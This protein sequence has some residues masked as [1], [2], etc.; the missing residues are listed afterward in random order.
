MCEEKNVL[1]G[2]ED[3]KVQLY[4]DEAEIPITPIEIVAKYGSSHGASIVADM[5]RRAR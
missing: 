1:V 2:G 4:P 3:Q 5:L